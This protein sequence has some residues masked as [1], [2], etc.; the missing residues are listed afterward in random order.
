MIRK[1]ALLIVA[2]METMFALLV[3]ALTKLIVGAGKPR[4]NPAKHYMR[5][6]GP[7]WAEKHGLAEV[8]ARPSGGRPLADPRRS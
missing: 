2:L 8:P 4:Y 6:P 5:G 7:K 3:Q 1:A